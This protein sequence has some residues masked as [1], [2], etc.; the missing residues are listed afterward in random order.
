[1]IEQIWSEGNSQMS[2]LNYQASNQLS[3]TSNSNPALVTYYQESQVMV[4]R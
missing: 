4:G 3:D 2:K 1:M